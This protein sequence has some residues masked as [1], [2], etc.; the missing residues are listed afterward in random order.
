LKYRELTISGKEYYYS[1][2]MLGKSIIRFLDDSTFVY[3]ERDSLFV[4][5]GN[6]YFDNDKK[7]II[8]IG[9]EGNNTVFK[10]AT[11]SV[12]VKKQFEILNSKKLKD[13]DDLRVFTEIGY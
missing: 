9:K 5:I 1:S 12:K 7:H 13:C 8:L 2:D 11:V 10:N 4:S 3:S 6:W